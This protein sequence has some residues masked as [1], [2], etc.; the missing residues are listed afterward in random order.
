MKNVRLI[1]S[2][3]LALQGFMLFGQEISDVEKTSLKSKED[4]NKAE[5]VV[6]QCAN[7]LLSIP[8]SEYMDNLKSTKFMQFIILW[9]EGTSKYS[10]EVGSPI[11][12]LNEKDK[13]MLPLF[14][15]ASTKYAIENND[16][17]PTSEEIAYNAI[18]TILQYSESPQFKVKKTKA[19]KTMIA[20][21]DKGTLREYIAGMN[22]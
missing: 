1:F 13:D 14:M 5:P 10:F 2:F 21:R 9:M 4:Y 18:L 8:H 11:M 6:L 20:E 16:K 22:K 12:S 7:Y 15:V 3:I 19:L 17:S